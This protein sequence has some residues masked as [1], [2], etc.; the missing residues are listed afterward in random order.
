[1]SQTRIK[2]WVKRV[3]FL[4]LLAI[5]FIP[6]VE[7]ITE[8]LKGK[9]QL[10]TIQTPLTKED[11]PTVTA[12]FY[13]HK[14]LS[15][16]NDFHISIWNKDYRMSFGLKD[17]KLVLGEEN[18]FTDSDGNNQTLVLTRFKVKW[19]FL[20]FGNK[21][22]YCLKISHGQKQRQ[23]DDT[24]TNWMTLIKFENHAEAPEEAQLYITTEENAYGAFH[25]KWFDGKVQPYTL[26]RG[27]THFIRIVEV[28][29]YDYI[30]SNCSEVSFY[31]CISNELASKLPCRLDSGEHCWPHHA[32]PIPSDPATSETTQNLPECNSAD[33]YD[34]SGCIWKSFNSIIDDETTCKTGMQQKSCNSKEYSAKDHL[35]GLLKPLPWTPKRKPENFFKFRYDM[36]VPRSNHGNR[37]ATRPFKTLKKEEYVSVDQ[38]AVCAFAGWFSLMIGISFMDVVNCTLEMSHKM[39]RQLWNFLFTQALSFFHFHRN[40][41]I[42]IQPV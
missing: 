35:D 36:A 5:G 6:A 3:S 33:A 15:Y 24:R 4:M 8:H 42:E 28:T 25:E 9:T 23:K 32:L 13:H 38:Q 21:Y 30:K 26:K 12:C 22:K 34:A 31:Q 27:K 16:P 41:R 19:W 11:L 18:Y 20:F 1:M 10:N 29:E 17:Y 37:A 7:E 40:R 2:G 39:L 14:N